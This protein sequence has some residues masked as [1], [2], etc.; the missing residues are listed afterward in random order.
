MLLCFASLAALT[1]EQV[2]EVVRQTEAG[3]AERLVLLAPL[4]EQDDGERC[5]KADRKPSSVNTV[6]VMARSG[7]RG[8]YSV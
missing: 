7:F 3:A 8:V 4:L 5:Y 6:A 1:W 2:A